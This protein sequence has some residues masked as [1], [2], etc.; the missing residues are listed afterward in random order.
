MMV[1]LIS[2]QHP[3]HITL[4]CNLKP[5]VKKTMT[6]MLERERH[7]LDIISAMPSVKCRNVF[8]YNIVGG[9]AMVRDE[10]EKDEARSIRNAFVAEC[11]APQTNSAVL[12]P[13]GVERA[14]K[15]MLTL[16][17]AAA[18]AASD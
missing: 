2:L 5:Y 6:G 4:S 17:E 8:K 11:N 10:R 14:F 7:P 1:W 16:Q 12:S 9:E 13:G 18:V 15:F 3:L